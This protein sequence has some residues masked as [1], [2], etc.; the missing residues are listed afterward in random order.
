M[1]ATACVYDIA[2]ARALP[3]QRV[4]LYAYEVE[5]EGEGEV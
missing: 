3:K 1:R 2:F 5:I 4:F